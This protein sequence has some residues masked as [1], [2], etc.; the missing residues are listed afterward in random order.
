MVLMK[1]RPGSII[2]RIFT[3]L[4]K[5]PRLLLAYILTTT[6][7]VAIPMLANIAQIRE[8]YSNHREAIELELCYRIGRFCDIS[9]EDKVKNDVSN[10]LETK[11]E[12]QL[13]GGKN[14]AERLK[15]N[16]D[17]ETA[18]AVFQQSAEQIMKKEAEA[19]SELRSVAVEAYQ[20]AGTLAE[21]AGKINNNDKYYKM[22]ES[23]YCS[24][25]SI[26]QDNVEA[27]LKLANL[28]IKV[29]DFTGALENYRN[30]TRI[31]N[32]KQDPGI[33]IQGYLGEGRAERRQDKL[34]NAL[35]KF[36]IAK[37]ISKKYNKWHDYSHSIND[38]TEIHKLR[39][40]YEEAIKGIEQLIKYVKDNTIKDAEVIIADLY[41]P[42]GLNY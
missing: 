8:Y 17:F 20:W 42:L 9:P 5:W 30:V 40:D 22:A 38:K 32:N 24:A 11:I 34:E 18:I 26:S 31:G 15:T 35:E 2:A 36:D 6:F 7:A 23:Y 21:L 28:Q 37:S 19:G 14:A 12:F 13:H 29:S 25:I 4:M 3:P 41:G 16:D 1:T 39:G 10:I 33:Q 27:I